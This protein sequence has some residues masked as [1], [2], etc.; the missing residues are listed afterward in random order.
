M[1]GG[2]KGG[3]HALLSVRPHSLAAE[4]QLL[5]DVL[6]LFC[7]LLAGFLTLTSLFR[8]THFFTISHA[9]MTLLAGTQRHNKW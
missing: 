7:V 2:E 5:L 4:A 9:E 8:G 3:A 1:L 6:L